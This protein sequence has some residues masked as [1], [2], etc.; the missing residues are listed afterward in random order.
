MDDLMKIVQ[1]QNRTIEGL[2]F[3][4]MDT[5]I[6]LNMRMDL[7]DRMSD[8][9]KSLTEVP[10]SLLND[11]IKVLLDMAKEVDDVE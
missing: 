8:G 5:E 3:Q 7:L 6:R 11:S 1:D 9:L 10:V 2:E 4:L